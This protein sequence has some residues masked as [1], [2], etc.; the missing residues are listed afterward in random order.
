[1]EKEGIWATDPMLRCHN[2]YRDIGIPQLFKSLMDRSI[3]CTLSTL[4]I[5]EFRPSFSRPGPVFALPYSTFSTQDVR[6]RGRCL[7]GTNAVQTAYHAEGLE[8]EHLKR[9]NFCFSWIPILR[10][11]G[12][13]SASFY[14]GLSTPSLPL[15]RRLIGC[16]VCGGS[17]EPSETV[18]LGSLDL[19]SVN[20]VL[21]LRPLDDHDQ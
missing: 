17:F 15:T 16:G 13:H 8:G 18:C 10:L 20:T 4:G 3:S 6:N 11:L 19:G 12:R 5:C 7:F 2:T 1:M 9:R 21:A 14:L